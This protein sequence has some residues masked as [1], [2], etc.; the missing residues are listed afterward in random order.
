M[1][2]SDISIIIPV[3]K[4]EQYLSRC[5]DSI[6]NQTIHNLEIIL[7]DDGSPDTC[8]TICD[9]Y[10]LTDSRI[11]VIHKKNGGLSDARNAGIEIAQGKYIGFVDSDDYVEKD[12]FDYLLEMCQKFKTS[13]SAC[14]WFDEYPN[15]T[16]VHSNKPIERALTPEEY[17]KEILLSEHAGFPI[18]F[19]L[20]KRELFKNIK[21]PVG[22]YYE[23]SY[24]FFDIM[25]NVDRIAL[26]SKPKYHYVRHEG[27]ITTSKTNLVACRQHIMVDKKNREYV[28][29]HYPNLLPMFES[30]VQ[31][32]NYMVLRRLLENNQP[33]EAD[34]LRKEVRNELLHNLKW[35]MRDPKINNKGKI[36]RFIVILLSENSLGRKI[37]KGLNNNI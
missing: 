21:F 15:H 30:R 17:L 27:T 22:M 10:A 33:H 6:T 19:R 5:I 37:L 28:S 12:M 23:D 29:S 32:T 16:I 7:V 36:V 1:S 9:K 14:G 20:Y 8:G 3:Y 35:I 4:A 34:S 2:I 11:R 24:V 31:Q 13:I 25:K 26:G 18:P